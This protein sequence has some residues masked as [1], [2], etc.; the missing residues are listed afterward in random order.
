MENV[1]MIIAV[2]SIAATQVTRAGKAI[3]GSLSIELG[4]AGN[5]ILSWV[6]AVLLAFVA[7]AMGIFD[8]TLFGTLAYGLL[9]GLA[10]NGVWD[11]RNWYYNNV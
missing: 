6:V 7:D 10:S 9:I 4:K 2:I 8:A 5:Q 1:I 11:I 3:L